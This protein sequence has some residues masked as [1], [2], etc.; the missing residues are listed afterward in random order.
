MAK[1]EK[2]KVEE[3]KPVVEKPIDMSELDW[4]GMS[5][6]ELKENI[7]LLNDRRQFHFFYRLVYLKNNPIIQGEPHHADQHGMLGYENNKIM[8]ELQTGPS[9][10]LKTVDVLGLCD[11]CSK[12]KQSAKEA[13]EL[14]K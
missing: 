6:S 3:V 8:V 10:S 2:T 13:H 4:E 7:H 14:W 11:H 9:G 12:T 5:G 1:K